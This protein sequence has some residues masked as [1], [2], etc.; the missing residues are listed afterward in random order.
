MR[1]FSIPD[2]N[3]PIAGTRT[4]RHV[5]QDGEESRLS[6]LL[7]ELRKLRELDDGEALRTAGRIDLGV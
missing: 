1:C 5:L 7:R 2:A 4:S 6:R 3:T